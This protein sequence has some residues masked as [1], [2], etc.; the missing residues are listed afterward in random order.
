MLYL[1][2]NS[3]TSNIT[4]KTVSCILG[5]SFWIVLDSYVSRVITLDVPICFYEQQSHKEIQAASS[6]AI[7]LRGKRNDLQ[8]L[9]MHSLGIHINAQ[10]LKNGINKLL[11]DSST[12][13]L[14]SSI[15]LVS[16]YPSNNL[17]IVKD[18]SDTPFFSLISYE[19]TQPA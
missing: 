14:P 17:I 1:V 10:Q 16:Y 9:D 5:L 6:I 3:L 12:L 8:T 11:I 13:F 4:L 18:K 15:K 19:N 2:K 7:T